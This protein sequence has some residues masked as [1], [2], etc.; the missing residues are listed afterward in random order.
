MLLSQVLLQAEVIFMIL[1]TGSRTDI[2]AYYSEWFYNRIREGYALT[3]NP[4]YPE[5]V[6]KYRLS[7][8]VVDCIIFC[9]K[10]PEPMLERLNE[11]DAF[12]QL[13]FVTITPY[14]KDIEPHVPD[15]RRVMDTFRRLSEAVGRQAVS[16]RYDP[17]FINE[18]YTLDFHL[19]HFEKMAK[20]LSGY[21]DQCVIS[22]ID[23]YVKTRKNFPG[24]K[25]VTHSERAVLGEHFAEVGRT[26]GMTIYSCCE[27][28]DL[29][30]FGI[31]CSG[32]MTQQVVERAIGTTLSVPAQ[33]R[34][35]REGCHCLLGG[36]IG[37]YNTCGHGCLYCY[38]NY[39]QETV[40]QNM[41]RHD[42]ASA[43]LTGGWREGDILH[44]ARQTSWLDGQLRFDF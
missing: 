27:G 17:I 38:A 26:C 25:A 1:N 35:A 43:F 29:A 39:D 4:F 19:E 14:G 41:R 15:K 30:R 28:D 8:E 23:L 16:W 24:V 11:L 7:P 21:T 22:F 31:D 6:I 37:M 9:T 2:P 3:R 36:D 12:K 5:Q 20:Y 10:N 33:G 42:P 40:R 13:W 34:S 32:C 18:T 44:K